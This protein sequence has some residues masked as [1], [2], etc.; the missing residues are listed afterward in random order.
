MF[1]F[2]RCALACA[3]ASPLLVSCAP[4]FFQGGAE[5][6]SKSPKTLVP[7][8]AERKAYIQKAAVWT[9]S[10]IASKDLFN[11]PPSQKGFR[12][13]ETVKCTYVEPADESVNGRSEKFYCDMANGDRIKVKYGVHNGE[14]YAEVA[15][16]RL[17]W[18][19]GFGADTMTSVRVECA[20][21]PAD[22]MVYYQSVVGPV[23]DG[24]QS[25]QV[26][27]ASERKT[28]FFVPAAVE[29]KFRGTK[30]E[31]R[32]D[33][34]WSWFELFD[35]TDVDAERQT[36]R[37]AFGLLMSI[38]GHP[39]SKGENQRLVCLNDGIE[40][41]ENGKLV[42]TKPFAIVQ[43]V[44][45]TFTFGWTLYEV[46]K[47]G[48]MDLEGWKRTP[49]W[50][51]TKSCIIGLNPLPPLFTGTLQRFAV[52]ESARAFL[53]NLLN[54]LTEKQMSDMFR[55]ARV[56]FLGG[57]AQTTQQEAIVAQWTSTLKKKIA[58]VNAV[59]CPQ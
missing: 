29:E 55:A 28:R 58:E 45:W 42:C 37:Q 25:A 52:R 10:D 30:I 27:S 22:P 23:I 38:L 21:C 57:A 50:A 7:T 39:D 16:T 6:S 11:G 4:R 8:S 2:V 49:V 17:L 41:V 48:K 51:D 43:D 32:E 59:R 31:E 44:G 1:S 24:E 56:E 35:F 47:I 34:G 13:G 36:H 54:Q 3:L 19:L 40:K 9:P 14:V 53:A 33:Q 15:A 20:N 5:V 12:F 26:V 18:A 46:S